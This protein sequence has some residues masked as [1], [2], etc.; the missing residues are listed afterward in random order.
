MPPSRRGRPPH[1]DRSGG[2][3]GGRGRPGSGSRQDDA[4]PRGGRSSSPRHGH[5]RPARDTARQPSRAGHRPTRVELT[6]LPGLGDVLADEVREV[7]EVAP[8][9]VAGRDD[10]LVVDLPT[11]RLAQVRRLRTA[12]A[13]FVVLHHDVPRPRSLLSGEHLTRIVEAAYASL[14][15]AGSST[16]RFE[17]AGADSP[18][19][20]RLGD[21]LARA[22]GLKHDAA[23][24]EL[25]V[26]VRRGARRADD[27][28]PG[29]D[30]LVRIGPRPLSARTWRVTDFP[31]AANAT[32]AAA[33][34]RL[35]GVRDDER[36]LNLM[37]GSGTL[38]IERLLAGPA[39][40]AVGIDLSDEALAASRDNLEAAGLTRRASLVQAD[41]LAPSSWSTG[42]A[43]DVRPADLVLAD[44]PWGTLHGSH[45]SAAQVHAGLLR[46]AHEVAAPGARL[47]V[48]THEVKVMEAAVRDAATLWTPRPAVRVFAKGHHPRIW[49]LDKVS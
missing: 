33:M 6:Y 16:F 11:D 9:P 15:V 13:A 36:V 10:A 21:E 17:A 43:T 32:I 5:G 8:R 4:A 14:R 41:A 46:A 40:A 28:D 22:T 3:S 1:P 18:T 27:A 7:L 20:L 47:V 39:A 23:D 35:A 34:V 30:V 45:A 2:F 44:P 29:W 38:L 19:F 12:V 37:S 42:P 26:K 49:V 48:L 25:V 31:G 24:G